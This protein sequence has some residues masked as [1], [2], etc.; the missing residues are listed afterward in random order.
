MPEHPSSPERPLPPPWSK[1]RIRGADMPRRPAHTWSTRRTTS[2]ES[3][4]RAASESD[5]T[6]AAD[7]LLAESGAPG[8]R[9]ATDAAALPG[10]SG[11]FVPVTAGSVP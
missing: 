7:E 10:G 1:R 8:P 4:H 5:L 9:S 6:R 3:V 2:S 11:I